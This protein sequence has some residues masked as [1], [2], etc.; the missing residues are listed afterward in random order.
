MCA[1]DDQS[2]AYFTKCFNRNEQMGPRNR[3]LSISIR[4]SVLEEIPG[5]QYRIHDKLWNIKNRCYH[6]FLDFV[7]PTLRSW[8]F[9]NERPVHT[10]RLCVEWLIFGRMFLDDCLVALFYFACPFS[11]I[12][13][14]ERRN[15]KNTHTHNTFTSTKWQS[16]DTQSMWHTEFHTIKY[17]TRVGY[18][19]TE[20]GKFND[21]T[22]FVFF[23][24][25]AQSDRCDD[26]KTA[27]IQTYPR[28]HEQ[29]D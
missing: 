5:T 1:F 28:I 10:G 9:T 27:T 17:R 20:T 2:L 12:F 24:E 19:L 6:R 26:A 3:L 4:C 11:G 21:E 16:N 22:V 18:K 15:K 29:T 7:F 13:P 25:T 14:F 23:L 8:W